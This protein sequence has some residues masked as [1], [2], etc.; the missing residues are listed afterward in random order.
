MARRAT[1]RSMAWWKSQTHTPSIWLTGSAP[2]GSA[3]ET[4]APMCAP[5]LCPVGLQ[6]GH[7][8]VAPIGRPLGLENDVAEAS[9]RETADGPVHISPA[10]ARRGHPQLFGELDRA[11]LERFLEHRIADKRVLRL[12]RKWLNAG[13]IENGEWS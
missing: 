10:F 9:T 1:D 11:W 4:M 6:F 5:T 12:I 7:P 13:V 8:V 3:A 2:F